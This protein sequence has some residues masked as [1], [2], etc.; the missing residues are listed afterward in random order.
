MM[1]TIVA[2]AVFSAATTLSTEKALHVPNDPPTSLKS[3]EHVRVQTERRR[4]ARAAVTSATTLESLRPLLERGRADAALT[5]ARALLEKAEIQLSN[6]R[7]EQAMMTL[8]GASFQLQTL[9]GTLGSGNVE[10]R[11]VFRDLEGREMK[12]RERLGQPHAPALEP[13]QAG[14]EKQDAADEKNAPTIPAR[15]ELPVG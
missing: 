6:G 7:Q 13:K 3:G 11:E 4:A 2:A 14:D 5:E 10:L 9:S 15:D 1:D 8:D 12:L